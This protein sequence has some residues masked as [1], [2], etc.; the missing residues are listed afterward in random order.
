MRAI[1]NFIS[2]TASSEL[3]FSG[4]GRT[5]SLTVVRRAASRGL[6][7]TVDP[8]DATVR[9]TLGSRAPLRPALAW[10]AGK[11]AWVEAELARLPV[12]VPIV[13]GLVFGLGDDRVRVEWDAENSRTPRLVI[14]AKAGTHLPTQVQEMGP[15]FRGDD[16]QQLQ[17]GG[18]LEALPP[19]VLRF[20]RAH[21][22]SVLEAET[23]QLAADHG[24]AIGRVGVGDPRTRWGSCASS[25]DIR[26]S[27]R[28]ILAPGFVRRATVAHE[29]AHRVHMNHGR[30]FHALAA[31]LTGADPAPSRQWLRAHGA[32]LH[33]FGRDC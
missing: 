25:G 12:A 1:L 6:R 13:P 20:L 10:A 7:L 17:V 14:P 15:R 2:S 3:A 24:I 8:S 26:Y 11:R 32:A 28:L 29:V 27:W 21:A 9:L 5:R 30:Q 33:W 19:R 22:L 31:T 16:E 4:G 23:R 18:P